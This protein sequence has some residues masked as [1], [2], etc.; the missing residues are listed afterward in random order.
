LMQE[1][2]QNQTY[3]DQEEALS[4]AKKMLD[5]RIK[6]QIKQAQAQ[7][8]EQAETIAKQK[9]Q[10]SAVGESGKRQEIN[11]NDL[12]PEEFKKYYGLTYSE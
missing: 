2:R 6:P 7:G 4:T 9:G 1:A 10:L 3:L 8:A 5:E 11:P 12:S